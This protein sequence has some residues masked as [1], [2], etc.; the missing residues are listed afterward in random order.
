MINLLPPKL[1][2]DRRNIMVTNQV[3]F[4]LVAGL[5]LLAMTT[6][7]F[8]IYN[9]ILIGEQN[10]L[11]K[12]IATE[13]SLIPSFKDTEKNISLIN[14]KLTQIDSVDKSRFLW[15]QVLDAISVSTP[16][17]TKISNLILNADNSAGSIAGNASSRALIALFKEKLES[18]DIF[19]SVTFTTSTY[20]DQTK[21][22]T[23][24]LDFEL[25]LPKR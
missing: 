14:S 9:T 8:Y 18:I 4:V 23:F 5:I 3:I 20:S 10:G 11:E 24:T 13:N 25:N 21:D 17:D 12:R 22:Y 16:K 6:A 2:K 15:S 7:A 1:K 19:K